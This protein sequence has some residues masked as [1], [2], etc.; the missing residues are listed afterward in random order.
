MFGN[1]VAGSKTGLLDLIDGGVSHEEL[2]SG[3]YWGDI[4]SSNKGSVLM[5]F[6]ESLLIGLLLLLQVS[7]LRS[8]ELV[9]GAVHGRSMSWECLLIEIWHLVLG[10]SVV[11]G[12]EHLGLC[13]VFKFLYFCI[14][15]GYI[16]S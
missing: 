16:Y 4:L 8:G 9:A 11:V 7:L 10:K 12:V 5:H 13:C 6:L 3:C 2:L 14:L 15:S 1:S